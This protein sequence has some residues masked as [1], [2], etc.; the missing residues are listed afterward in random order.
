MSEN[1]E[2]QNQEQ[3]QEQTQERVYTAVEQEALAQGWRPKEEFD[4]DPD[5]FIDAGEFVR[6]GELFSKI[7]HQN[8]ELKQLRQAI[9]Q[10]KQ[11]HANVDKAAYDRALADLKRQRKEAL[12]EGDVEKFAELDEQVEGLKE[13]RDQAISRQRQESAQAQQP[14]PAFGQWLQKNQ[15]YQNDPI[16]KGAA[17]SFGIQ[18]A[19]QG[20]EP[21]E[22]L[23]QVE[24]KIKEE[25]KH[26]FE[27]P[28]RQRAGAVESPGRGPAAG[29]SKYQPSEMEKRIG[30]SLV[31][32]KA[33][34]KIEDYYAELEKMNK[35]Q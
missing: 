23:K 13:D 33:F 16:M 5:R 14:D 8:R 3:V 20:V 27:N 18:L 6:R 11:H 12:A 17:D 9:D 15:W 4:G 25:F 28:N 35:G 30:E 21:L 2:N 10:F 29:K 24:K 1:I 32:S 26:K 31:R 22:V 19:K 34:E 7:D